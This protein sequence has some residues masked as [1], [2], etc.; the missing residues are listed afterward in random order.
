MLQ[1]ELSISIY[2]IKFGESNSNLNN[3]GLVI[4]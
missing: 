1:F 3:D 4:F 2:L